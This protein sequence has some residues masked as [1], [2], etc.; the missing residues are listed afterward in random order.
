[1]TVMARTL[2]TDQKMSKTYSMDTIYIDCNIKVCLLE[3]FFLLYKLPA[4]NSCMVRLGRIT[5]I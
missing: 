1:M 2:V 4:L 5:K 3:P